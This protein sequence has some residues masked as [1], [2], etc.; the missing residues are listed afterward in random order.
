MSNTTH[1]RRPV[2]TSMSFATV[3]AL[4]AVAA[5]AMAAPAPSLY[6]GTAK[7]LVPTLAQE[8]YGHISAAGKP[9][10]AKPGLVSS[11][12]VEYRD[13][14]VMLGEEGFDIMV[15]RSEAAAGAVYA[16]SCTAGCDAMRFDGW[17]FK[18]RFTPA[19]NGT[20]PRTIAIAAQCRNVIVGVARVAL[21]NRDH[22][23]TRVKLTIDGIYKH[24]ASFG[25]TRC[26]SSVPPPS[27]GTYY[28]GEAQAETAVVKSAKVPY[29]KV[30]PTDP[31]CA[32]G[33]PYALQSAACQGSNEKDTT[34]TYARFSCRVVAGYISRQSGLE[35]VLGTGTL[36]VYP[37]GPSTYRWSIIAWRAG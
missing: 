18:R 1:L 20:D 13:D 16:K 3:A 5:V 30:Q 11:W 12:T 28:W 15:F 23:T 33:P 22:L 25:M 2:T 36:A 24:A 35:I 21:D 27:I 32:G 10:P 7:R 37:T 29:C 26:G 8:G 34:F 6:K 31:D 4:A 19:T 9:A 17:H 14:D